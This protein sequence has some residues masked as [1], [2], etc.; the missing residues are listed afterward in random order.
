MVLSIFRLGLPTSFKAIKGIPSQDRQTGF[1][2]SFFESLFQDVSRLC[3]VDSE[4]YLSQYLYIIYVYIIYMCMSCLHINY[5]Y[6]YIC[7]FYHLPNEH[8]ETLSQNQKP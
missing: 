3:E 4:N 8:C 6:I 7:I 5:I 1:R 2:Y